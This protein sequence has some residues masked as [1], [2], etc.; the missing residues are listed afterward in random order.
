MNLE[1]MSD[2]ELAIAFCETQKE[3]NS[4]LTEIS[5]RGMLATCRYEHRDGTFYVSWDRPWY[6]PV[7]VSYG[8]YNVVYKD[9]N[10]E[11]I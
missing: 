7:D 3:V 6:Q 5:K 4:Y 11:Q 8:T 10:Y 9:Q 2:K 1:G